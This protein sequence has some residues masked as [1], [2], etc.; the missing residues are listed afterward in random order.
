MRNT[1]I[2]ST[3]LA[4]AVCAHAETLRVGVQD[5][6]PPFGYLGETGELTGFDVDFARAVC[7]EIS[8]DCELVAWTFSDLIPG[9]VAGELDISVASLSIT[10][11]R[12]EQVSFTRKYYASPARFVARA[13]SDLQVERSGVER[14]II[15]VKRGTTFESYL[16]DNVADE[17]EIHTYGTQDE[18]LLD[19][20]MDRLH[21][22]FGDHIALRENFLDAPLGEGFS[23]IGPPI[24]DRRWFGDGIGIAVRRERQE[25]VDQLDSAIGAIREDGRYDEIRRRYFS[26]DIYGRED[27][28]DT[29]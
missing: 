18:A 21:A 3:A 22:V 11:E 20:T 23:F 15:G 1:L 12:R 25:L 8:A 10:E 29:E 7:L 9:L 16:R 28:G 4:A 13:G 17:S 24:D 2:L 14:T 5:S 19:L 6:S 27:E 26:Y